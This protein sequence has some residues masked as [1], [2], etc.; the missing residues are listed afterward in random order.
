MPGRRS[1]SDGS[2]WFKPRARRRR[3]PTAARLHE[4]AISGRVLLVEE[5]EAVLEFERDVLSGAGATV[6]TARNGDD[7]RTRLLSEAI[8]A[9]IMSGKMAGQWD[10][11]ESFPWLIEN[12]PG[13]EYRVL[14]TFSNNV[15]PG[16]GRSFLEENG[17]LPGEAL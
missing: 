14:Y 4:G 10:A 17:I 5:E 13:M 3:P 1:R 2:R 6:V 15:E 8:D 11:K 16:D 9:V 12:C 7:V